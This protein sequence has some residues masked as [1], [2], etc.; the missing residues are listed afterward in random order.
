MDKNP[1]ARFAFSQ[2]GQYFARC[3]SD[4][5][6]KIWKVGIAKIKQKYVPTSYFNSPCIILHWINQNI[7]LTNTM[8]SLRSK[9]KKKIVEETEQKNIIIMGFENGIIT[10]YD[11][12]AA[13]VCGQLEINHNNSCTTAAIMF[14][15]FDLFAV[16]ND[17]NIVQWDIQDKKVKSKWKSGCEE[18]TALAIT[19]D[20][21]SL[22]SATKVITW[23]DVST[24]N[25]VN[26]FPGH[27]NNITS[28]NAI[29]VKNDTS[30]LISGADEDT[31]LNVWNLNEVN[32]DK[33]SP[34][35][36]TMKDEALSVS[37]H[38][39]EESKVVALAS[40]RLGQTHIFI[41]DPKRK[42]RLLKPN[43]T[44]TVTLD[45]NSEEPVEQI[46]IVTMKLIN[47]ENLLLVY[48]S[49]NN[50][51]SEIITLDYSKKTQNLIRSGIKKT[52]EM[53]DESS[54]VTKVKPEIITENN[55][56]YLSPGKGKT[57]NKRHRTSSSSSILL[58]LRDR[59]ESLNLNVETNTTNRIPSN[60]TNMMQLLMQGLYSM[61]RTIINNVLL[62]KNE[63]I[64]RSTVAKL[65]IQ[66]IAP[67]I[68]ELCTML[69]GKMSTCIIAA[70]WLEILITTHAL[71]LSF[72]SDIGEALNPILSLIDK[73][74]ML[75]NQISKLRGRVSLLTG[76]IS[77]SQED[78][79]T[80][81]DSLLVYQVADSSDEG[82]VMEDAVES[83][84]D[85]YWEEMSD[86][87]DQEEQED[88]DQDQNENDNNS[89]EFKEDGDDMSS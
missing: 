84:S 2:D 4:G 35:S 37:V 72:H 49:S 15:Y 5:K 59:L 85:E 22:F 68:K 51:I 62:T 48:G 38:G 65:P 74:L 12:E 53:E 11:V 29:T 23:W 86:Q 43:L 39:N 18:V 67:L 73:K 47:N 42:S 36:L 87:E 7:Q 3:G 50:P 66:A 21:K 52:K 24:K 32:I 79:D 20:G 34:V 44:I 81:N 25:I 8:P 76:Q 27:L 33:C 80:T 60:G 75:L 78:Q 61:D 46:P 88:Q 82:P 31:Y 41:Y 70:K 55:G 89:V 13:A 14:K 54:L 83:G 45:E 69:Q 19:E 17:Y 56:Q 64:I 10:L 71:D 40:T 26:I 1:D 16:M 57:T 28:L 6:L 30:Y 58:P 9:R 63:K 77:K